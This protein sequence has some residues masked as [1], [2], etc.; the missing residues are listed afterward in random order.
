[1]D[2]TPQDH[3][4]RAVRKRGYAI[5]R[6]LSAEH[7]SKERVDRRP[8][9]RGTA[10]GKRTVGREVLRENEG[11]LWG[12]KGRGRRGLAKAAGVS[13]GLARHAITEG[14]IVLEREPLSGGNFIYAW[15]DR[16]VR[17]LHEIV[18]DNLSWLRIHRPGLHRFLV[19]QAR[20]QGRDLP[21]DDRA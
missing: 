12:P 14:W 1:M 21:G 2:A 10:A 6:D 5:G 18:Y 4:P 13:F 8:T 9:D 3:P 7:F 15:G 17:R 19:E 11:V 16:D 20:A